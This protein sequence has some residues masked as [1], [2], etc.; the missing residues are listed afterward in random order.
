MPI[1]IKRRG[2]VVETPNDQSTPIPDKARVDEK[3]AAAAAEKA[4]LE[5]PKIFPPA[6]SKPKKCPGCGHMYIRPCE[7]DEVAS[8]GNYRWKLA[9]DAKIAA[10]EAKDAAAKDGQTKQ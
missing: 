8:C 4:R 9:M 6:G 2:S 10:K 3:A 1:V 7:P 5:G